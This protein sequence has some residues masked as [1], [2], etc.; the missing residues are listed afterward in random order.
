MNELR[1][2]RSLKVRLI[3]QIVFGKVGQVE[4]TSSKPEQFIQLSTKSQ[5]S[6]DIIIEHE[7]VGDETKKKVNH[8][9]K[10]RR[11]KAH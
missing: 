3:G 9:K 5:L 10:E 11:L 2:I 7:F 6:T 8:Q 1:N 4:F